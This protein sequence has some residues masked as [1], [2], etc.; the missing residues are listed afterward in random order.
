[1]AHYNVVMDGMSNKEAYSFIQSYSL[2][3]GLKKFGTEGHQAVNKELLQLHNR[4]VF[5]PI[6]VHQLT[7]LEKQRAMEILIFLTEKR[8]KSI[9]ARACAN[10]STQ[11]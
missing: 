7:K 6:H 4:K 2:K 11:R 8:D 3:Q 5:K 10:G 9:K 1:M